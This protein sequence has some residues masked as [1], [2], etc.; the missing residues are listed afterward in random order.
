MSVF[1]PTIGTSLNTTLVSYADAC[2]IGINIDTAADALTEKP[3][4]PRL[5]C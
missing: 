2:D 1:G 3:K 5:A 4:D